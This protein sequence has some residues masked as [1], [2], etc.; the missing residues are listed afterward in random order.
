MK[1]MGNEKGFT[2]IELIVVIVILGILSAVAIP[3]YA[4][5]KTDAQ[6]AAANGVLGGAQGASAMNFAAIIMGK[7][8]FTAITN[9]TTLVG[10]LDGGLPSG[11]ALQDTGAT[12][13][14]AKG[15][16]GAAVTT[17][18]G[19]LYLDVD[20][21]AGLSATDYIVNINTAESAT[22]KAVLSKFGAA[23]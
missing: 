17:S 21:T 1:V 8:G 2:L 4:D 5:F 12:C 3:K 10:A 22:A 16:A 15:V 13:L 14:A 11:W 7:A 20:G 19:C 6:K 9:A 18:V 23:Y